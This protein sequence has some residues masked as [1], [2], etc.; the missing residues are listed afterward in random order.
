MLKL[1]IEIDDKWMLALALFEASMVS[2]RKKDYSEARKLAQSSLNLFD[3]IN[4]PIRS[5]LP[6]LCL[7]H[8][9]LAHCEYQTATDYYQRCLNISQETGFIWGIEKSSK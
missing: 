9:A 2:L 8:T 7:G 6:L 4:N 5:T 1:A 3:E